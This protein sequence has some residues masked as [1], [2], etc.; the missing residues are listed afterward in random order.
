MHKPHTQMR[1]RTTFVRLRSRMLFGSL[2]KIGDAQSGFCLLLLF[3]SFPHFVS[4]FL[5]Q[6]FLSLFSLSFSAFSKSS[7]SCLSSSALII[8]SSCMCYGSVSCALFLLAVFIQKLELCQL[9]TQS[10]TSRRWRFAMWWERSLF[11]DGTCERACVCVFLI[12]AL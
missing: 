11:A 9:D 4:I 1:A 2:H 3:V 6:Y 12:R 8:Y 10:E 7:S 5:F